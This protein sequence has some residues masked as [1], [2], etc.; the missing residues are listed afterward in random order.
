MH[1]ELQPGQMSLHHG[2]LLHA[3]APNGSN[4]RRIGFTMN[5]I[6]A[7]NRQ[8]VAQKDYAM[9]VRGEDRFGHFDHVPPPAADLSSDALAWH[10]RILAAQNEAYYDGAAQGPS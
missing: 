5:F 9:L 3:S 7:S 6:K 10:A 1:V 4:E 8:A 2:R